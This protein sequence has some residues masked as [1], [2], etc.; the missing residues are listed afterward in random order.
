MAYK[1][2]MGLAKLSGSLIQEGDI[3]GEDII[4][5]GVLSGSGNFSC[6]GTVRLDGVAD[7]AVAVASDSFYFLDGDS[8]MKRDTMADYATAIAGVGLAAASG[9]LALDISEIGAGT[10][11]TGDKFL[12]LDSDNSTEQLESVDDLGTFFA[13]TTANSALAASSGVLGLDI[14]NVTAAAIASTDTL[15]F[16]DQDGDVV[17]Q[18]SIDDIAALFAGAGM[19]ASAAVIS[20]ANA[21]NGGLSIFAND[22]A[23][24]LVDLSAADV[25]VA[26]DSIAI[27]DANDSDA[28]RKESIADLASGM[29]GTVTSTGLA[30]A[31]GVI[32]LAIHSLGAEAIASG[33]SIAFS[34][35]GDNGLH[36]ETVDDLAT[37]FAGNGLSAASAVM[38]LDLN[39]LSAAAV[40]VAN[41]SIAIVDATDSSSKKES[42]VDLV[43]AMAGTGLTASA[44]TLNLSSTGGVNGVGD[45]NA[46]LVEGTN[47]GNATLTADRTWTLPAS[48]GMA[49]GDVVRVKAPADV[50]AYKIIISKA[51]SQTIDGYDTVELEADNAALTLIYADTDTWIIV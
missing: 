29:C 3:S 17:R 2:Q 7:A 21:T 45:A 39:E 11:A 33:D 9:V 50:G 41:D 6:G 44:G 22:M 51:G 12:M 49:V 48:V 32:S 25:D 38:A 10:V 19:A 15:L 46:T 35:S 36:K 23:V 47:F 43:A 27:I 1:F 8:L 34:D 24:S 14:A 13:G 5:T 18:E 26:A 20:V 37:L 4:A 40:D 16:N 28:T 30:A 42:I 31:S